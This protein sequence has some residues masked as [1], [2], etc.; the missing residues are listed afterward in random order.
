MNRHR[1]IELGKYQETSVGSHLRRDN[2]YCPS[3]QDGQQL[4]GHYSSQISDGRQQRSEASGNYSAYGREKESPSMYIGR[5]GREN[6]LQGSMHSTDESTDK[7]LDR[8]REENR[9]LLKLLHEK[10]KRIADLEKEIADLN[11]DVEAFEDENQTLQ[12]ENR[13]LINAFS[14]LSTTV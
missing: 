9:R 6:R 1:E 10:D 5:L 3:D 12:V 14:Q 2:R 4:T 13:A 8:E 11:K 7:L